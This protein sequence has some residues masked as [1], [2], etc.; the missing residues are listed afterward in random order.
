[1]RKSIAAYTACLA[2]F[3]AGWCDAEAATSKPL[4]PIVVTEAPAAASSS[5]WTEYPDFFGRFK[6]V[7]VNCPARA[8]EKGEYISTAKWLN[9]NTA[10]Y[11]HILKTC[12]QYE[13]HARKR[14]W[15]PSPATNTSLQDRF[16]SWKCTGSSCG[17]VQTQ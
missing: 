15:P 4:P 14:I 6:E 1:M 10:Q 13:A 2:L 12:R 9:D 7:W 3:P 11:N 17:W 16:F 5:M 8:F